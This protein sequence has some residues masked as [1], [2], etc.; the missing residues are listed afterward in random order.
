MNFIIAQINWY[1]ANMLHF[2]LHFFS[3]III[4][5]I[6]LSEN[7]LFGFNKCQVV[8]VKPSS[9][10]ANLN[11]SDGEHGSD[12]EKGEDNEDRVQQ[13]PQSTKASKSE[14]NENISP[15]KWPYL[16]ARKTPTNY[17]KGMILKRWNI[18]L[19]IN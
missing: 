7:N 1:K 8:A 11:Q 14:P 18:Y 16:S 6:A 2:R 5:F 17:T 12:D 4:Y 15:K 3:T 9:F 19:K 10:Q 13:E